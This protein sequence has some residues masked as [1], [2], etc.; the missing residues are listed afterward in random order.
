MDMKVDI[1]MRWWKPDAAPLFLA[2]A[3]GITAAVGVLWS[4]RPPGP[5]LDPDS[6]SY[7]AAADSLERAGELR[8][9]FAEWSSRDS[10]ARLRD[11][12]PGFSAAIAALE[13]TGVSSERSAT[14]VEAASAFATVAG[15]TLLVS[16]ATTPAFAAAAAVVVL[17]TP[18]LVEDHTIVLS[19]PLFLALL[20]AVV[21]LAAV[22]R[23]RA[24]ALGVVAAAAVMVRYA[25]L[26][27][28]LAA[29]VRAALAAATRRRRFLAAALAGAPGLLAFVLWSRW[30][31]GAREYGW[32]GDFGAT[33]LEGW[34]TLQQ[35]LVPGA[36]PSR[37]SAGLAIAAL[38]VLAL[39]VARGARRARVA[40]PAAFRLLAATGIVAPSYVTLVTFSRLFADAAIPF[41]NR[42]VSPL[43]AVATL[44]VATAIGV[45][46]GTLGPSLRTAVVVAAG[47]WCVASA[48]VTLREL[49]DLR[50]DGWGYA[51][52][53]WIGSDLRKWLLASGARYELFSDNPPSLYSLTHRSSRSLP[54][55][56]DPQ[57]LRR[58]AEILRDR[59]SAV[60]AFQEPDAAPRARGEDFA[61]R[62]MLQQVF[63]A[64]DGTVFVLPSAQPSA[65][66]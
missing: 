42:I 38:A 27:L 16:A 55:S 52:A 23:P 35:W 56:I 36:P 49:S 20:V 9:P 37:A 47:I 30:A 39:L 44:A 15:S 33:I 12:A 31:G 25:G 11:F 54:E 6:M 58:L 64:A 2:L 62:L 5:G 4:M 1:G 41:D 3:L 19:E 59:P 60:I 8:V 14:W 22:E 46:W 34:S 26:S 28:V 63:R 45:Q 13:T 18:A 10:T 29:A 61:R 21:A 48:N 66:P 65:T 17:V 24:S 50:A 57:T 40:S 32:K 53:E 7:L 43:F 51:S